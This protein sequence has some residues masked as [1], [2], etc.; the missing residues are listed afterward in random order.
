MPNSKTSENHI[1]VDLA[2]KVTKEIQ[3]TVVKFQRDQEIDDS[4]RSQLAVT[5][6]KKSFWKRF[7]K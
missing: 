3:A 7:R 2:D 1:N 4:R 5:N 6:T